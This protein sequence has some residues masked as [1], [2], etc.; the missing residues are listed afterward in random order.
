MRRNI[1]RVSMNNIE[2]RFSRALLLM[3]LLLGCVEPYY[4]PDLEN[5]EVDV[6]IVDGFINASTNAAR[7][8]LTK[9][10]GLESEIERVGVSGANVRIESED[11][12]E[13]MLQEQFG[14]LSGIYIAEGLTLDFSKLYKLKISM[15]LDKQY[16]SEFIPILETPEIESIAWDPQDDGL[17]ILVNSK[18]APD[19]SKFYRWRFQDTYRYYSPYSSAYI[20]EDG[21]IKYRADFEDLLICYQSDFTSPIT[22][23]S[24][25]SLSQN[26]IKNKVIHRV[27]RN[28]IKLSSVYSINVQQLSITDKG[29]D[30]W[31]S[32]D[33]MTEGLG[34]LFDPMPGQVIGNMK[35]ITNPGETVVGFFS[36]STVQEKRVFIGR[37][38]LP[39]GYSTYKHYLCERDSVLIANLASIPANYMIV[40]AWG[41]PM[42]VGYIT[43]SQECVDCKI[44]GGGSNVKPDFWP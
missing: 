31:L 35:S 1:Q 3:L 18:E 23:G 42:T 44:Y 11:G 6:L 17:D 8:S 26:T 30:Y 22:I 33:K 25:T 32:L 24:T 36:G 27:D 29:Y 12:Q 7:V 28:S 21:E 13:F 2:I 39:P 34:G 10:V 43:S 14:E 4:P 16:E 40:D 37:T 41:T 20:Y 9:A 15:E 38:E 19:K 5:N